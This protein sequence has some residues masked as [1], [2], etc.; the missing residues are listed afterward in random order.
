[1]MTDPIEV[2]YDLFR[3]RSDAYGTWEGGSVRQPLGIEGFKRHLYGEELIGVY[4]LTDSSTVRWGCSDIDVDDID[5]ARNLQ[6]ALM[7]KGVHSFVEKTRRG[8]HVWVFADDWVP[9]P[10]MRRAFLSAHAVVGVPA[11]EV[12]PKQEECTGLGNYVRL[13]YPNG[14]NEM[15]E[16]RYMLFQREDAPMT[17]KQFLDEAASL[18]VGVNLLKPLAD[19]YKPRKRAVVDHNVMPSV[20]EALQDVG[21]VVYTIWK[22]GPSEN[23]DRSTTLA[24][25]VHKCKD[26]HVPIEKAFTIVVDADKRWGKFHLR[27]DGMQHLVKM[28]EDIYGE[29]K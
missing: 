23:Y 1:M 19:L 28:V 5:S 14:Y 2:F 21:G 27:E 8:F 10:I 15:P 9:A 7:V 26:A 18:R 16:N 3:G 12:N 11:K 6:T 20:R 24:R 22:M 17:L 4:P 13:P 25:L 29:I